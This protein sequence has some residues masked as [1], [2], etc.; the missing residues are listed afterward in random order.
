MF[1]RFNT[2]RSVASVAG[3]MLMRDH[4]SKCCELPHGSETESYLDLATKGLSVLDRALEA[5]EEAGS[6]AGDECIIFEGR[7][8]RLVSQEPHIEQPLIRPKDRLARLAE[9]ISGVFTEPGDDRGWITLGAQVLLEALP[10]GFD[11]RLSMV[12]I[13]A[14]TDVLQELG[15]KNRVRLLLAYLRKGKQ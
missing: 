7:Q 15:G 6:F 14:A 10:H 3:C 9:S 13:D 12:Q 1:K 5:A 2:E 8:V 4:G 11:G